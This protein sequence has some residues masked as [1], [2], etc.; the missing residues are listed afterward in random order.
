M[1][2][3]EE[4]RWHADGLIPAIIQDART[5]EVLT[6]AYLSRENV[7][8]YHQLIGSLGLRK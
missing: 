4:I 5:G 3:P 2:K 6:L 7:G 1:I 8:R